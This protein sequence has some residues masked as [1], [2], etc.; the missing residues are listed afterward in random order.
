MMWREPKTDWKSG[1]AF[2][3]TDYNRIK[4]NLEE[5][6]IL[7][8]QMWPGVPFEDMGPDKTYED[9]SFYADEIN[10]FEDNLESICRSTYP[11]QIGEKQTFEANRPFIGSAELNRLESGIRMIRGYLEGSIDGQRT[12]EFELD[13]ELEGGML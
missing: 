6:R 1:D 4:G 10:R 7:A 13:G 12:L 9:I 2:N 11:F 8:L 3:V 5:L